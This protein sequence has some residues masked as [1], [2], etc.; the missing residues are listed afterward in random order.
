LLPKL[1][2]PT[3]LKPFPNAIATTFLGHTGRV[4]SISTDPT[5]QYLA[6]G[7]DDGVL[8]V[9][10]ISLGKLMRSWKL[11]KSDDGAI[12]S[13]AWGPNP[14]IQCIAACVGNRL[15]F[16]NP[17]TVTR[18]SC[19]TTFAILRVPEEENNVE[20]EGES[21]TKNSK[22]AKKKKKTSDEEEKKESKEE[23]KDEKSDNEPNEENKDNP[24]EIH[25]QYQSMPTA[26]FGEL[27]FEPT[28]LDFKPD[29]VCDI[30]DF[31][32]MDFAE[33]L[34]LPTSE[35]KLFRVPKQHLLN[36]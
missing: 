30:R 25:K 31:W 21:N 13:V 11:A 14:A 27:A 16:V 24:E 23:E 19:Q 18:F 9:W 5:G 4:R 1:P 12:H 17:G 20:G 29:I 28:C 6:S 34:N 10:D 7:G 15:V 32:M 3:E 2:D 22:K 36:Q 35:A 26:Q 8:R 33:R